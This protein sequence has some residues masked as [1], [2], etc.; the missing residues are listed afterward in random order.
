MDNS[1]AM[2]TMTAREY[3]DWALDERRR[4]RPIEQAV[5]DT[6]VATMKE[7]GQ[8]PEDEYRRYIEEVSH[9]NDS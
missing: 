2:K 7:R 3:V 5:I 1:L 8:I 9:Q 6:G 4:R